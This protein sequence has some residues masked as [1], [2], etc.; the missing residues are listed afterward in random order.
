MELRNK[1]IVLTGA[2]GGI[3]QALALRLAAA[4]ACVW[5]V[6]RSQSELETLRHRMQDPERHTVF[7]LFDYSDEEILALSRCFQAERR[8]DVL[9]NNAGTSR[10]AR[11]VQQSPA[12]IREQLRINVEIPMI[13]TSTLLPSFN[14][15][16]IILNVG[17]ILGELGHPGYSVYSASKAALYRFSEALGRELGASGIKVLYAAPRSAKTSLNS[18]AVNAMNAAL[19]NKSD[20]P[21]EVARFITES[22]TQERLRARI[23]RME[24][25]FVFI[26]A[27]FPTLV[28][29]ALIK[30]LPVI[31]R[32]LQSDASVEMK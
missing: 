21:D 5:L 26:N 17:S 4:G 28:D 16:A 7:A 8:I 12:D 25:I 6:G 24:R 2:N 29:R 14:A 15:G 13:L 30:K 19:G 32:F 11:L 31:N 20:S 18:S 9:I 22:L 23:G 3:G 1:N 10:F 27:V